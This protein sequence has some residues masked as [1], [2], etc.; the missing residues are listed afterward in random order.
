[1]TRTDRQQERPGAEDAGRCQT[2]EA[3]RAA[4]EF[5]KEDAKPSQV[6]TPDETLRVFKDGN[7][8]NDQPRSCCAEHCAD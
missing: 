7:G 1:M 8:S 2:Q 5:A 3:F 4:P 6:G